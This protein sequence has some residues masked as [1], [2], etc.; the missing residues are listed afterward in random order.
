M[1]IAGSVQPVIAFRRSPFTGNW[2]STQ[3]TNGKE[4]HLRLQQDDHDLIGWEGRLPA[5]SDQLQPDLKG[6]IKGKIADIEV[7]HRRGY[8]AHARLTMQGSKL[9]WQLMESDNRSSRYFPLA[10]TLHRRDEDI[11][12]D[13]AQVAPRTDDGLLWDLL[14]HAKTVDS[15]VTGESKDPSPSLG[16][17]KALLSR[18]P[19]VDDASLQALLKCSSPSGRVYAACMIWDLDHNAGTDVFKSLVSDNTDVSYKTGDEVIGTTISK[20]AQSFLQTGSFMDFP[21]KRY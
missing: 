6:T 20:I 1:L 3:Y 13:S 18:N 16:A 8:K 7:D 11:A 21:S 4:F 9:V 12:G 15:G 19:K 14:L 5:N 2:I 10:S 17:Y